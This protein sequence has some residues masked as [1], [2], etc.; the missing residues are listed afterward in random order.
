M[1][2]RF[3]INT[4]PIIK[5]MYTVTRNNVWQMNEK[6]N[7]LILVT[8]G[9]CHFSCDNETILA[10]AGDI[11]FIPANTPYTRSSSN[12]TMCTMTYIHFSCSTDIIREAPS[13]T[14]EDILKKIKNIEDSISNGET[15]I[16]YPRTIYLN[17]KNTNDFD[18]SQS[19]Y[20]SIR[21]FS[22]KR[23]IMH[24]FQ[25]S[26]C[27]CDILSSLS[28]KNID[29]ILTNAS[30]KEIPQIPSN[31]K[32]SLF[33]IERNYT[34][35]ISLVDLEKHCNIS[36][37]QLIRYFKKTF[38][39]TPT[40]YIM[41]Y[42]IGKAKEFLFRNPDLSIKEIAAE[43]GYDNQHYFSRVFTR[44]TGETPSAYRYR[45]HHYVHPE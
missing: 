4:F 30:I 38:N 24:D 25:A 43:L 17:L 29:T 20:D 35:P 10:K 36:K 41:Q 33:F 21:R 39:T 18:K 7:L 34:K 3:E 28:Q 19:L 9:K 16:Q 26:I 12:K 14:G 31:L 23:Q 32:K 22:T 15:N 44:T 13:S 27:L 5:D 42:K 37:Q 8:D 40:N 45:V 1:Y 11:I 6:D 2:Y